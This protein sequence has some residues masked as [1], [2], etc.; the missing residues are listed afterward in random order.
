MANEF[1]VRHVRGA[2]RI[3]LVLYDQAYEAGCDDMRRRVPSTRKI[4]D[5]IGWAPTI[6]IEQTLRQIVLSLQ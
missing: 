2:D 1:V 4:R 3:V 5:A 6:P